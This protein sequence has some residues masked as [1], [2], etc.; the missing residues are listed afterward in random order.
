MKCF[1][2][3]FDT[4]I[5][6]ICALLLL[7]PSIHPYHR[8][9]PTEVCKVS[10]A[11]DLQMYL[12]HCFSPEQSSSVFRFEQHKHNLRNSSYWTVYQFRAS[13]SLLHLLLHT[14]S[15]PT[16][17]TSSAFSSS[18]PSSLTSS[19][20]L[21]SHSAFSPCFNIHVP[22]LAIVSRSALY[23]LNTSYSPSSSS[24]LFFLLSP[25]SSL[26]LIQIPI[27]TVLL[28]SLLLFF[29]SFFPLLFL[30]DH[31]QPLVVEWAVFVFTF[32]LSY[33]R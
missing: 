6:Y 22:S 5:L 12:T 2:L 9:P 14:L 30:L 21:L 7:H 8:H 15:S 17:I 18:L 26:P 4:K 20:S 27:E 29:P 11:H 28:L 19:L 32:T 25:P 3:Y 13:D 1:K 33:G 23:M 10:Q 16:F 31:A 24:S